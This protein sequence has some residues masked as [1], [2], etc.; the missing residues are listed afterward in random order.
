MATK[1]RSALRE[2]DKLDEVSI[3][4]FL[5]FG[6]GK[7]LFVKGRVISPYKQSRPRSKNNWLRNV[8]AA[9]R[10]YSVVTL[11]GLKVRISLGESEW[12]VETDQDGVFEAMI[13]EPNERID[14][15]TFQLEPIPRTRVKNGFLEIQ[16]F[17][18]ERG[19]ISDID[20]TV[21]ISHSTDIGKKLWLSVS[22]NAYTRRPLPGV[23]AFYERLTRRGE[24]PLFYVSSSDWSLFDLIRDFLR[25][26]NIPQGPILLK[27]QHI[28]LKNIWKSGGGGHY[29]KLEKLRLLF[30]MFPAMRWTLIGD[31]GQHDPEIYHEISN[32]FPGR[33]LAVFIRVVNPS[34]QEDRIKQRLEKYPEF[35]FVE[36]TEE[37]IDIAEKQNLF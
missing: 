25:Y 11:P 37:A 31:S 33:V 29:H 27:D 22:K 15:V 35:F 9:V 8:L 3:E 6:N 20:D 28:N 13:P 23:S 5:A 1:R 2:A 16:R 18:S 32:E 21:L 19:V 36:N 30:N 10:R 26:R 24:F 17:F 12:E 14:Q 4:P 7:E 34:K